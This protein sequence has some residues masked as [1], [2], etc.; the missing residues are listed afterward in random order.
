MVGG[1]PRRRALRWPCPDGSPIRIQ[2]PAQSIVSALVVF[3]DE[4]G[5]ALGAQGY[6]GLERGWRH[7]AATL[8][9]PCSSRYRRAVLASPRAD[10]IW[11]RSAPVTSSTRWIDSPPPLR[12]SC[13]VGRYT[14][15][16]YVALQPG[17]STPA[18][19]GPSRLGP[20]RS[21]RS[22]SA[23][24]VGDV[25]HIVDAVHRRGAHRPFG[26][27]GPVRHARS[28]PERTPDRCGNPWSLPNPWW[29]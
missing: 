26:G 22:N 11:R 23:V 20:H 24:P 19:H 13:R 3:V 6:V 4:H 16:D 18:T 17:G 2:A 21:G 14:D 10:D 8:T 7:L 25:V 28:N 5:N 29:R 27:P 12:W 1:N 9:S 15:L